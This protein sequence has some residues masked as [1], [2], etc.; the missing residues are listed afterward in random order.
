MPSFDISITH[1]IM[2]K[3]LHRYS[4]F[5]IISLLVAC[6]PADQSASQSGYAVLDAGLT[7][8]A[9][10]A[11]SAEVVEFF[12]YSCGHCYRLEAP[13]NAWSQQRGAIRFRRI[14]MAF[15]VRDEPLQR[16]YYVVQSQPNAELL[17]RRI[18]S[19]IHQQKIVLDSESAI[20]DYM[21]QLGIARTDFLAAYRGP[22]VQQQVEHALALRH[23]YAIRAVPTLV[24]ADRFVTSP[25]M[26]E[27]S[28]AAADP[29]LSIEHATT[30]MLDYLL[31][32]A[33][34]ADPPQP[35]DHHE[36]P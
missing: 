25:A 4:A 3:P 15:S 13:L 21:V 35:G 26:V 34:K 6:A 7:P 28:A 16:L 36:K 10:S 31:A 24:V 29:S 27:S 1:R 19:A 22:V 11:S 5:A 12:M 32:K 14:P 20:A 8:P 30:R 17:H 23:S 9:A 2:L 18:F 33:E